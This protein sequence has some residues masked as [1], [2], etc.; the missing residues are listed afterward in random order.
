MTTPRMIVLSEQVYR[1]LL[2]LYPADYR[3]EYGAL[4]AQVFRD[5]C[6]AAYQER[7]AVGMALWWCTTLPDLALTAIEQR[8]KVR[9]FVLR[10]L[11]I[12][13]T[14]IAMIVGGACGVVASYSQLQP[15]SHYSYTGIYQ[16]SIMFLVPAL[17]LIGLGGLGMV[18]RYGASAGQI[19]RAALLGC[20]IGALLMAF[21]FAF[22][23][24]Q[25]SLW[26]VGIVGLIVHAASA[27]VF[28]L[29]TLR[30]NR[31]PVAGWLPLLAGAIL[32]LLLAGVFRMESSSGDPV[33]FA[34]LLGYSVLWIIMGVSIQRQQASAVPV[35]A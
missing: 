19:G 9:F 1:A 6:R 24:F 30:A 23:Q 15:G 22:A 17:L 34:Y 32:L 27:V 18:L 26:A 28:G 13:L 10:T 29:T 5:V 7:G 2:V 4:M 35:A 11:I 33:S 25:E 14:G 8:R 12:Q 16:V 20:G 3:H 31:P 21:G